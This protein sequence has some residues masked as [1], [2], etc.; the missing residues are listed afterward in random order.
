MSIPELLMAN[1]VEGIQYR[2]CIRI[3]PTMTKVKGMMMILIVR[4]DLHIIHTYSF[5]ASTIITLKHPSQNFNGVTG[6]LS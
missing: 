6:Q 3:L 2:F 1:V 4:N 5:H